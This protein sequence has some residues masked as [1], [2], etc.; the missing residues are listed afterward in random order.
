MKIDVVDM[1]DPVL[2]NHRRRLA[3]GS[4]ST[5]IELYGMS[6]GIGQMVADIARV[7]PRGS[8]EVLRI[9][10]HGWSG[11][12]LIAA[13]HSSQLG[14]DHGSALWQPNLG[15]FEPELSRLRP[16][17]RGGARVELKGCQV[18][19]GDAGEQFLLGLARIFG[20]NVVGAVQSQG[21]MWVSG[22]HWNGPLVQA[23]PSGALSSVSGMPL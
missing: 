20:V 10:G 17:F 4:G 6:N 2:G 23:S 3:Q 1:D 21:G 18:A 14:V 9:W 12:Q 22:Q 19:S 8:V 7:A 5:V 16:Y 15:R 11:G 13:G